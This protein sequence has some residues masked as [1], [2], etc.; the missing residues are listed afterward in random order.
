MEA[1]TAIATTITTLIFSEALKEGGKAL[2]KS[3]SDKIAQLVTTIRQ[4][5]KESG[6]EGLLTR[7]EKQPTESNIAIVEAELITQM[8]NDE[9]FVRHLEELLKQLEQV[10]VTRQIMVSGIRAKTLEV[11]GDMTQKANKNGTQVMGADLKIDGDVKFVGNL[12]Q[13]S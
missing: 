4:R 11:E 3:A 8:S 5:F 10:G 13:Q 9:V 6:T 12:S 1:I 7:A 2:G